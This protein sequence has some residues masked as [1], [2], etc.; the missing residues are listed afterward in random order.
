MPET[1]CNEDADRWYRIGSQVHDH[2]ARIRLIERDLAMLADIR[3]GQLNLIDKFEAHVVRE[4]S[5]RIKLMATA[6]I[7]VIAVVIAIVLVAY[8]KLV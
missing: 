8:S 2:E 7:N 5:D 3:S 1:T 4:D 6:A